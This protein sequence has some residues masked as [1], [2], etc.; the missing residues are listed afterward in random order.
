[1]RE[2]RIIINHRQLSWL[3][4]V[5]LI[6]GGL[7]SLPKAI[8]EAAKIDGWLSQAFPVLYGLL[9]AW[10]FCYLA[11]KFPGKNLFEIAF[12]VGGKWGGSLINLLFFLHLFLV[13][14]RDISLITSFLNTTLL[15]RTPAEVI[16]LL[17]I[18]VA[19]YYMN[20]STEVTARVNDLVFPMLVLLI[21]SLPIM[22]SNEFTF[23]RIEP[24]MGHGFAPILKAN[25]L[26]FGWYGDVMV[27]G[28]FLHTLNNARQ[29]HAAIRH[30]VV[31]AGLA[32]SLL[33]F[34][35]I[36]VLGS[37]VGGRLLYTNYTLVEQIHITDFLDRLE[38]LLFSVWL[39]AVFLK[40]IFKCHAFLNLLSA[41]QGNRNHR[42]YAKQAGWFLLVASIASFHSVTEVFTFS[43]YGEIVMVIALNFPAYLALL[44]L[45]RGKGEG[46]RTDEESVEEP[47]HENGPS[48]KKNGDKGNWFS[49]IHLHTWMRWT[50]GLLVAGAGAVVT[51]A[52]L[53]DD[54]SWIG[55]SAGAAYGICLPLATVTSFLELRTS[56][57]TES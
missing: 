19:V 13:I 5:V 53:G 47:E 8:I 2:T 36:V 33:V 15:L 24:I 42:L 1:M 32:M 49:R 43:N 48:P 51:G 55:L 28:A 38:L 44:L 25:L 50:N 56:Q 41:F 26:A 39:P 18:F 46:H 22:L 54:F 17:F 16:G 27:I 45:S 9:I 34:V 4:G 31:L 29:I 35:A 6:S 30:G 37:S 20:T 14:V 57:R 7:I 52:W 10:L 23:T 21:L 12:T 3:I 40:V 11:K